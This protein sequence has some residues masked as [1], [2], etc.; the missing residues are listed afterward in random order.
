M[1]KFFVIICLIFISLP[2]RAEYRP[3]PK[4]LSKQYKAEMEQIINEGYP[5]VIRNIDKL[6]KEASTLYKMVRKYGYYS[7]HQ[8]NVINLKLIYEICIPTSELDLYSVLIQTTQEKYLGIKYIP[9]S[10]DWIGPSE[11]YLKPYFK[12]NNI[13]TKK[14]DNIIKYENRKNKTVKKYIQNVEKLRPSNNL[15]NSKD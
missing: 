2:V 11:N 15:Y 5:Q 12:D 9:L 1:K 8:M 4:E 10:T 6:F 3:I 7:N 14:L 13:N